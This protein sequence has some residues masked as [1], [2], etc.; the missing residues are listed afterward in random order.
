MRVRYRYLFTREKSG[1]AAEENMKN[2][3][4]L[5]QK[6]Y[7]SIRSK[8]ECGLLPGGY[9]LP[10]RAEMCKEFE[11]SEK[12]VRL[13]VEMLARDGFV[14]T[15]PRKRPTVAY[16]QDVV[17]KAAE[18]SLKKAAA[19][20]A[21]DA[22]KTGVLLCYP[23]IRSGISLCSGEDWEIPQIIVQNMD[24]GQTKRFWRLSNGFW[25]FFV[26]RNGNEF[27]L[28]TVESLGYSELDSLNG[29]YEIRSR[30]LLTL[31]Q[32]LET[33]RAGGDP[34]E[35]DF[36]DM[37]YI[38]GFNGRKNK[39]NP[40]YLVPS[41][42][43]FLLGADQLEKRL[44]RGQE[45]YSRVYLDIIGLIIMG[46]YKPGSMLP[47]HKEMKSIYGVSIDTTLKAVKILKEWGV[48]DTAPN[49]G[50][51]V[52]MSSEELKKIPIEPKL[53]ACHVRRF[54]DSL[55]LLILIM[56]G[57]A[58]HAT[59][60]VDIEEIWKLRELLEK[61]WKD[62]VLFHFFPSV[63]LDFISQ[64]IQYEML[65]TIYMV[66]RRNFCIG[67]SIPKLIGREKTSEDYANYRKSLAAV[68]YLQ[69]GDRN[70]FAEQTVG[71][72]RDIR[73]QI[74]VSCKKIGYWQAAMRVYDGTKLWK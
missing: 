49:K 21:N 23:I 69:R 8:I 53:I 72:F 4:I 56:E 1:I 20:T 6:I 74:T 17:H 71:L 12:P 68:D 35:V 24:P 16:H 39:D 13:A 33:V 42:S 66:L 30:Y 7:E 34:S 5:Y 65:R 59:E 9:Q 57:V 63:L 11:T 58:V 61:K 43:V 38:Y 22:L 45:Q 36:E 28:R 46:Y 37:S 41:D 27:I 18:S 47:S 44:S 2:E 26:A 31:K 25:H 15:E 10:S 48:V 51:W 67:R 52:T 70:G 62:P 50:I 29:S 64:H 32:F 60:H 19:T 54:L 73:H 40:T 55:E 3:I 14:K